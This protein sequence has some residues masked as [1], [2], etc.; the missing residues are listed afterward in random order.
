MA[1]YSYKL[2]AAY[3]NAAGLANIESIVP[4]SDRAFFS[5]VVF[6]NYKPGVRKGRTDGL[7]YMAGWASSFWILPVVTRPQFAYLQTTYCAGGFSG[8]VTVAT[9]INL[10]AYA[11]YNAI[12]TLPDP[13]QLQRHFKYYEDVR[14]DFTRMIPL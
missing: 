9:R 11:N 13:E 3:N 6:N 10:V 5:P 4:T 8:K 7:L 1:R 2:A 12:L 14:L